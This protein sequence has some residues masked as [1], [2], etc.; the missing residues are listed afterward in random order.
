M[1]RCEIGDEDSDLTP[2][3]RLAARG[4]V[5]R[6]SAGADGDQDDRGKSSSGC[7]VTNASTERHRTPVRSLDIIWSA[8]LATIFPA[9]R[10]R[11]RPT[12]DV[13]INEGEPTQHAG[14]HG[15]HEHGIA[16]QPYVL[17]A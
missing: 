10:K 6:T 7:Q 12:G 14:S 2:A 17:E 9:S 8:K 3:D 11:P 1:S 16:R 15:R 5:D 13:A 4:H